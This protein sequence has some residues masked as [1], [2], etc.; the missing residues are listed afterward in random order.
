MTLHLAVLGTG[1]VGKSALTVQIVSNHFVSIYDPTIEDSYRTSFTVDGEV[2]PLEILD[3]AG[4]EEYAALRDQ[5]MRRGDGF[6]LVYSITSK[7]SFL[8]IAGIHDQLFMV[9]DKDSTDYIPLL[10]LGNK[11][12]LESERQVDTQEAKQIADD[13]NAIF[14]ETSAKT[15]QN[16]DY[17]LTALIKSIK[18]H[19]Q[20][21]PQEEQPPQ[22][23]HQKK[24]QSKNCRLF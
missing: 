16:I 1:A 23:K 22:I 6:I 14:F 13:W 4:Q 17:A 8:E 24:Y 18:E 21:Q 12:D 10:V 5:Y 20:H 3:T 9:L 11:L 15:R 2:I 7:L 19:K